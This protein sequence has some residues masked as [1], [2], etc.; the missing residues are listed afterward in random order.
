M[1]IMPDNNRQPRAAPLKPP[2]VPD[3]EILALAGRGA[4]GSVWV[5][6]DHTNVLHALKVVELA[7]LSSSGHREETALSLVRQRVPSHPHLVRITH[8]SRQKT[9]LIYAME[10]ADPGAG[11]P[12]PDQRGYFPDTLARRL[13]K[14]AT[15]PVPEAIQLALQLLSALGALHAAKL[16]HR[17][18]KPHNVIF[19]GGVPKLADVGLTAIVRT[20]LSMAGTPGYLPLDG[21]TGPDADL[22][23]LGKLLYQAITGLEPADFPTI[24]AQLLTGR[25]ATL[26]LRLNLFLLRACASTR[27]ERFGEVAAFRAGL[28]GVVRPAPVPGRK[29]TVAWVAALVIV[30][31]LALGI[32]LRREQVPSTSPSQG[33]VQATYQRGF[34]DTILK[35]AD[36]TYEGAKWVRLKETTA[37]AELTSIRPWNVSSIQFQQ[38]IG[39]DDQNFWV[40]VSIPEGADD[41]C[42][43]RHKNGQWSLSPRLKKSANNHVLRLLGP[44]TVLFAGECN[45]VGHLWEISPRGIADL[46]G[47]LD[48]SFSRHFTEAAPIAPD[49][50]FFFGGQMAVGKVADGKLTFMQPDKFKEVNLHSSD[51][52]PE[53][54]FYA[55]YL[56]R[57]R[58][59]KEGE[60]FAVFCKPFTNNRKLGHFRNGIWH[61][62]G[63][64]P[65]EAINNVWL[66]GAGPDYFIVLVGPNSWVHL[67]E[68]GGRGLDQPLAA[69]QEKT[70]GDLIK[71]WGV[72]PNKFWVMDRSGTIW[73]RKDTDSRVVVLGRGFGKFVDAWVSPKGTVIAITGT[74]VYRLD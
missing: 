35:Y 27:K 72:S 13:S 26:I 29:W 71:A 21:S 30:A 15:I 1:E 50:Y 31:V 3:Y 61:E 12:P 19:V 53:K 16:V 55:G 32:C 52:T 7:S 5:A 58:S 36:R 65:R 64:L 60:A 25:N 4:F 66:G 51:N 44:E 69:S 2:V 37:I 47:P 73:E 63:D 67:H 57:A 11:S 46:A 62:A 68:M 54:D 14:K 38:V 20:S 56:S 42:I 59:P 6:R 10:L 33:G 23:A 22:Y 39:W 34:G 74:D 70:S 43:F 48:T 9:R 40:S 17:D 8:V 41:A 28:E 49:L 45:S 18:V 24:P